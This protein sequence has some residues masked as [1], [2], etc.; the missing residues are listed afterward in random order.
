MKK[1]SITL[2]LSLTAICSAL[3]SGCELTN[4]S[5]YDNSPDYHSSKVVTD[6]EDEAQD[7]NS[8]TSEK[9]PEEEA[10]LEK[11]RQESLTVYAD[12]ISEIQQDFPELKV[13]YIV[14]TSD[15]GKSMSI[16]LDLQESKD[17]TYT[18]ASELTVT[19]ESLLNL[20]GITDLNIMVKNPQDPEETVGILMF[21]NKHGTFNPV[22]NT[23]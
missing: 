1:K 14:T 7:N 12:M 6:N 15:G 5:N 21:E 4:E 17:A 9:S 8:D 22:V 16:N 3:F 11:E 2:I 18:I 20:N 23:L 10:A 13:N 19:K